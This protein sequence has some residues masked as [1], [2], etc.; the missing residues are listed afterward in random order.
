MAPRLAGQVA[1]V[2]GGAGPVGRAVAAALSEAGATVAVLDRDAAA[3][4]ELG[5]RG[6]HFFEVDVADAAEV[7]R[8]LDRVAAE[9]GEVGVLVTNAS[10][11]LTGS[12]LDLREAELRRCLEVDVRGALLCMQRV[13][14]RLLEREAPGR[15]VLLTSVAGLRAVPGSCAHSMAKAMTATIGQVAA[16]ELGGEGITC[17][18]VASGWTESSFLEEQVDRDLA[19]AATPSARLTEPAEVGAVCA[20]LA[21]AASAG[22]N[23]AVIPVDGGY[24]IA[25]S[26]GGSP[27]RMAGD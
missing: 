4:E 25:K 5:S 16:M 8:A 6:I 19:I 3:A 9:L 23:G 11:H 24:A 22:V 20:F 7:E 14:R 27:I 10:H 15:L 26:P 13:A 12:F 21:S 17:N 1:V 18:V 2:S